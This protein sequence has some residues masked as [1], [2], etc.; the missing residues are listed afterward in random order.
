MTGLCVLGSGLVTAL[1]YNAPATLAA[2]RA[3][4]T[5][6]ELLPWADPGADEQL[7]GARVSLPH[8]WFGV[9]MLA[10]MIA[11]AIRECLLAADSE[12]AE[13]IP[14]L[15]GVSSHSRVG[16]PE[17]LDETL[18]REV[19]D[20]LRMRMHPRSALIALDQAACAQAL[21]MAHQIISSGQAR[22]VIVAGVDSFLDLPVLASYMERRRLKT[23]TNSNGFIPAEAG[24]AVLLGPADSPVTSRLSVLGIGTAREPATIESTEPLQA[25]GLTQACRQALQQA[26][27]T[28][29]DVACR[30]TDLSGEHYKFKEAAFVAGRLDT[31]IREAAQ[32]LWHPIEYLGEIGAAILPCLLAQALHAGQHGYA[33]GPLTLIHVG[34]DAGER[35]ALVVRYEGSTLEDE[36]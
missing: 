5:A 10:D 32:E 16:R 12:P 4:I 19:Q 3:G 6:V 11:P 28:M 27:F 14:I 23:A 1:G 22:R 25:Q 31:E 13:E 29:R 9:G 20:R 15:L 34:S 26:G 21:L 33:P 17:G 24:C 36:L 35:A 2:L 30:L 18:L 8:W 7:K